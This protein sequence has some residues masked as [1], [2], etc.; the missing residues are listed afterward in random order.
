MPVDQFDEMLRQSEEK[1]MVFGISLHTFIVGQPFPIVHLR[2]AFKQLLGHRD[3][4][5]VT[6]PREIARYYRTLP[7]EV[8]LHAK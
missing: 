2:R 1:P 5:W 3:R 6:V 4:I 8:Q 7:M